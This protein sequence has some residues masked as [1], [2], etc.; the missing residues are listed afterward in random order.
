M[1]GLPYHLP[2]ILQITWI[3]NMAFSE[4]NRVNIMQ[5]NFILVTF[6]LCVGMCGSVANIFFC[7]SEFLPYCLYICLCKPC[8]DNLHININFCV[9]MS[10]C[11]YTFDYMHFCHHRSCLMPTESANPITSVQENK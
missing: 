10:I 11:C 9:Y 6:I 1:I 5:K 3:P 4:M 8:L 7:I 2:N